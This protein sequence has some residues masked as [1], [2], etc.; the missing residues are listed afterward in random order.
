MDNDIYLSLQ[1]SSITDYPNFSHL[2]LDHK[3][4]SLELRSACVNVGDSW[5]ISPMALFQ[6]MVS[7]CELSL[8]EYD[9]KTSVSV[10]IEDGGWE[11]V[12]LEASFTINSAFSLTFRSPQLKDITI[13]LCEFLIRRIYF[14]QVL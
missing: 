8:Q 12:I 11:I 14:R 4:D 1:D 9:F 7:A 2:R 5:F 6:S 3:P 13:N 10:D